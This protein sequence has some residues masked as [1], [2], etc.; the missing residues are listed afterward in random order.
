MGKSKKIQTRRERKHKRTKKINAARKNTR[1]IRRGGDIIWRPYD[2]YSSRSDPKIRIPVGN[3]TVNELR[4][5]LKEYITYLT[6][7]LT[8]V[9]DCNANH[10]NTQTKLKSNAWFTMKNI[11]DLT[12]IKNITKIKNITDIKN[13]TEIVKTYFDTHRNLHD[14]THYMNPKISTYS[15][16]RYANVTAIEYVIKILSEIYD[17]AQH[18]YYNTNRNSTS[19]IYHDAVLYEYLKYAIELQLTQTNNALAKKI[20]NNEIVY[21]YDLR[22]SPQTRI[23]DKK[24]EYFYKISPLALNPENIEFTDLSKVD[25]PPKDVDEELGPA[26]YSGLEPIIED[27]INFNYVKLG[28]TDAEINTRSPDTL[29]KIAKLIFENYNISN[30]PPTVISYKNP[31]PEDPL[32]VLKTQIAPLVRDAISKLKSN[33]VRFHAD[34]TVEVKFFGAPKWIT[35][36]FPL[37]YSITADE[38]K[39]NRNNALMQDLTVSVKSSKDTPKDKP[40]TSFRMNLSTKQNI[41][42]SDYE[43]DYITFPNRDV[44]DVSYFIDL[45]VDK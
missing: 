7:A 2:E 21:S 4:E 24:Y 20:N 35:E 10:L 1:K 9:N 26:I 28:L 39:F 40:I 38:D 43:I 34:Y 14:T 23:V 3:V 25:P 22:E 19:P 27:K 31:P 37:T 29:A 13:I 12:D 42:L 11:N 30:K 44:S 15:K 33:P 17:A 41:S 8:I 5:A 6:I 16:L 32:D 36:L 18:L 45:D